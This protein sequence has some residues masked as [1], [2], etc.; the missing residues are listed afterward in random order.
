[1]DNFPYS[2]INFML[3]TVAKIRFMKMKLLFVRNFGQ[4]LPSKLCYIPEHCNPNKFP[5]R[6]YLCV[7]QEDPPFRL[8]H[9]SRDWI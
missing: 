7:L 4:K 8:H 2:K 9:R 6:I 3:Q 1:M 5:T